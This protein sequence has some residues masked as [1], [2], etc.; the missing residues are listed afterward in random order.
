M[1][2]MR[3]A[4]LGL[5]LALVAA[6]SGSDSRVLVGG[7]GGGGHHGGTDASPEDG[8]GGD[9]GSTTI[10]GIVCVVTDLRAPFACGDITESHGVTI[11]EVGGAS[12]QSDNTGAFTLAT[13]SSH[14]VLATGVDTGDRLITT[15]LEV[16]ATATQV[17]ALAVDQT[18]FEDTLTTLQET[19]TTGAMLVYVNRNGAAVPNATVTFT[20]GGSNGA[21]IYYDD[22]GGGFDAN[23]TA[24][25]SDGMALIL[26]TIDGNVK[27]D[28]GT[29]S[30]T[31]SIVTETGGIGIGIIEL[32]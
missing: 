30:A 32:Q 7:G 2:V 26:D 8:G 31:V 4:V 27:A 12:T 11:T 10:D 6:C 28:D 5:S 24:T 18:L 9:G 19:Q 25:G 15:L 29:S 3:T 22:G 23:A 1:S 16:D 21:R 17:D 14:P 20:S 13:T